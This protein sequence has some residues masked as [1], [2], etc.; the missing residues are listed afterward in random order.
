MAT[1]TANYRVV[2]DVVSRPWI[3]CP[4]EGSMETMRI[5]IPTCSQTRGRMSVS[6]VTFLSGKSASLEAEVH[7]LIRRHE[8]SCSDTYLIVRQVF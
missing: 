7:S 2:N 8:G 6:F 4:G 5:F 3:R 1:N